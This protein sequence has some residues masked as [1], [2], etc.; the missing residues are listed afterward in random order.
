MKRL[1]ILIAALVIIAIACNKDKFTTVPQ[2]KLKSISP[3]TVVTNDIITLEGSY[4]DQE[5][6]LDSILV[7]YKWFNG[8]TVIFP[9]DTLR[10]SFEGLNAPKKTKEA[11]INLQ[12]QYNNSDP[13]GYAKLSGVNRDT[14][15]AFGMVL[16]D[17]A[18]NRSEYKESEK[19]RIKKP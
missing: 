17:E 11:D 9:F 5:G 3:N 19:I 16:K 18:G 7:V 14:T 1:Y 10:Y 4:T 13:N 12:F 8:A 15:A 6:D 2:L